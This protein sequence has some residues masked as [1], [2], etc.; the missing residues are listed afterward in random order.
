MLFIELIV[1][2]SEQPWQTNCGLR[3][4]AELAD[5]IFEDFLLGTLDD[6]SNSVDVV[7]GLIE[8]MVV[9]NEGC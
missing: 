6:A 7:V 8:L 4:L 5:L 3:F 2:L 9:V 1:V